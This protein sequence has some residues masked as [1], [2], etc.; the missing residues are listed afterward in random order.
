MK[1]V[2]AGAHGFVARH[3]RQFFAAEELI[4][5][6]RNPGFGEH[7]WDPE[8]GEL[9]PQLIAG[10]DLVINLAGESIR[11][12]WTAAKKERIWRSRQQATA[13]LVH[14]LQQY[15]PKLY[16]GASALG[17]YGMDRGDEILTEDSS[18]GEGYLAQVCRQ[19][20]ALHLQLTTCRVICLR[21]GTIIS[22]DGGMLSALLPLFKLGLGGI[23]G[24]GR[25]WMSLIS[26]QDVCAI[27]RF[28]MDQPTLSGPL[29]T[30]ALSV[31][32]RAWTQALGECVHRPTIARMP[33][34]MLNALLGE[35]ASLAWGSLR[36]H[37][38]KLL[39][40]GYSFLRP[41]LQDILRP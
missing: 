33:I 4:L 13:L 25:Q 12:R 24:S 2:I 19:W 41:T 11:G 39:A 31:T 21:F 16:L 18:S 30:A 6:T 10:A 28:C 27:C 32:N 20:E 35:S 37:P 7:G 9:D 26:I 14:H 29:N 23:V 36:L 34:W 40:A 38:S 22:P 3:L 17:Y 8:G 5:L 1:I 15:P